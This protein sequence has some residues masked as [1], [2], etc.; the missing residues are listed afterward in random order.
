[1]VGDDQG[2]AKVQACATTMHSTPML[3]CIHHGMSAIVCAEQYVLVAA[4]FL[5]NI[6]DAGLIVDYNSICNRKQVCLVLLGATAALP[7][8]LAWCS[9]GGSAGKLCVL[10]RR[11]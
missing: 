11:T 5:E 6:F 4:M 10:L 2:W 1:M 9:G 3:T 7:E 8:K